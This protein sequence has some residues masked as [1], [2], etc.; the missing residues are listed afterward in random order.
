MFTAP[1]PIWPTWLEVVGSDMAV[2]VPVV[3]APPVKS[4]A[5]MSEFRNPS[6]VNESPNNF[7]E[8][9]RRSRPLEALSAPEAWFETCVDTS[10]FVS[11]LN[12]HL[13]K[14]MNVD[15]E[16]ITGDDLERGAFVVANQ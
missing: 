6:L 10:K 7:E 11:A 13:K 8:F 16:P 12:K 1:S 4:A 14:V 2:G 15:W 3:V 9:G 5:N